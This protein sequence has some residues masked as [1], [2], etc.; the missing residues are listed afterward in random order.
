MF[1]YF[2]A[3]FSLPI[4]FSYRVLC[5]KRLLKSK[6]QDNIAYVCICIMYCLQRTRDRY[7]SI[8]VRRWSPL[9]TARRPPAPRD[10]HTPLNL[11]PNLKR[12]F[13][14]CFMIIYVMCSYHHRW[15]SINKSIL[16]LYRSSID[17]KLYKLYKFRSNVFIT[18]FNGPVLPANSINIY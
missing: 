13:K 5:M 7:L 18:K 1:P 16:V 3:W 4:Y 14:S 6:L 11:N 10:P 8:F 12:R 2:T 9:R 15:L 17:N